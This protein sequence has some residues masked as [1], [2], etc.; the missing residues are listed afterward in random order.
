MKNNKA[1]TACIYNYFDYR[2]YLRTVYYQRKKASLGFSHR[3]F[4]RE[5]GISSPNYLFRVLKGDRNLTGDYCSK[6]CRA[7][8]LNR[9][10]ARYF[11]TLVQFN[12]EKVVDKKE[13]LLRNLLALR[14]R[15]GI[16]RLDDKKLQFFSK[17]YY[18]VIRELAVLI[19][20]KEDYNLLARHC[21]PRITAQQAGNALGYLLKTGFLK[22]DKA[23]R[24]F[25]TE[26]VIS[27]GDEVKSTVLRNYHRQTLA[28]SIGALDTVD[29]E[30]RD[31]SSLT[32][33]V[34]RKTY[35]TIKKEIQDFRKRLLSMAREDTNPEMVCLAGFQLIPRSK[36]NSGK[37]TTR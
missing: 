12:V 7:L 19:D 11:N 34:S 37:D 31:V 32:L 4:S 33:S 10:E 14:Y 22:K 35:F 28:Q 16:F 20:C 17:W 27:S 9:N 3:L 25:R 36:M 1:D 2:E 29:L 5:A 15:R 8:R 23:G 21:V 30:N 18:P 24:Y 6:F 13:K 26:P